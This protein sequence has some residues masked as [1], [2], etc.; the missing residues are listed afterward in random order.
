MMVHTT[1]QIKRAG[2][3]RASTTG[4][5]NL[6]T[7]QEVVARGWRKGK[8]RSNCLMDAEFQCE[9][10]KKFWSWMVMVTPTV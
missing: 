3:T 9:M 2:R 10:M 5:Y 6:K 4:V 8:M 1:E 7:E